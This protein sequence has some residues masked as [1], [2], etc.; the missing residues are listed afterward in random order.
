MSA[1]GSEPVLVIDRL[2]VDLPPWAERPRAVDDV[3][4]ELRQDEILCVVGES[5]SG[6]SVMARA[7]LGLFPSRHV[8][9][10]GGRVLYRG[11]D[12]LTAPPARLR[13]LRGSRIAMIFQEPMTALN[14]VLTL[15]RQI[16]EAIEIHRATPR[17]QR[18]RGEAPA[19]S[20]RL[21]HPPVAG[22]RV[23][24][25]VALCAQHAVGKRVERLAQVPLG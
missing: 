17:A 12:L 14:P 5:G 10:S 15:G 19:A 25:N 7:I 8:K 2:C 3:S 20:D 9:P 6:K 23:E 4:L 18:R 13:E 16:E 22:R 1:A 21:N 24:A 11:E